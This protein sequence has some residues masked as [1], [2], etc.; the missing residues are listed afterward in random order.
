MLRTE[1]FHVFVIQDL[2]RTQTAVWISCFTFFFFQ[3]INKEINKEEK[4]CTVNPCK[5]GGTCDIKKDDHFCH[6]EDSFY[7]QYCGIVYCTL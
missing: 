1:L 7:G 5:N 6:C 2:N 4:S 3:K